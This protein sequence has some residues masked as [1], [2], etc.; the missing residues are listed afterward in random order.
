MI[1][2][3]RSFFEPFLKKLSFVRKLLDLMTNVGCNETL[4]E[5]GLLQ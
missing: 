5:D 2:D 3:G 1:S 4:T